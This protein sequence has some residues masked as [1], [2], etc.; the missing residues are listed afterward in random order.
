M[1]AMAE[2]E[3][4]TTIPMKDQQ[5]ALDCSLALI[6]QAIDSEIQ[7][8]DESSNTYEL[9]VTDAVLPHAIETI[10][11]FREENTRWR[12]AKPLAEARL[13][14]RWTSLIWCLVL[15]AFSYLSAL[16]PGVVEGGILNS[17]MVFEGEW[18]RVLTATMLH[19]DV[20]HLF[21]NITAGFFLFG[22]TMGRFGIGLGLLAVV[23]TGVGGN[24]FGLAFHMDP[25]RGLGASGAVMGAL[26]ML[27]PHAVG[28]MRENPRAYRLVVSGLLGV[29][30]LFVLFGTSPES[31]VIAHFGGFVTGI[32]LGVLLGF[33]REE[34]LKRGR[35]NLV[36]SLIL[37][38]GLLWGWGRALG[39]S[40]PE[41][42]RSLL[43][44][45]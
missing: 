2:A 7:V 41:S 45:I 27:G 32:V 34:E 39:F 3:R 13:S 16:R 30:M 44:F 15:G 22:L 9:V 28:L 18:W 8:R 21:S 31:D 12:W 1:D 24:L 20:A 23:L 33:F 29:A 26:G 14:F 11:R 25:Y 19:R 37:L 4:G 36:A 43:P 38:G 5:D 10:R 6:S 35:W 42:G 17:A 40:W